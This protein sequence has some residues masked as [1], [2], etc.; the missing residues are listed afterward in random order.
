MYILQQETFSCRSQINNIF[1]LRWVWK[2][3]CAL[4]F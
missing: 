3:L 1:S 2:Q 4:Q